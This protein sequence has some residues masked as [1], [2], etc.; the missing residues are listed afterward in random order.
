M[1]GLV[2]T[3]GD[4]TDLSMVSSLIAGYDIVVAADSGLDA[5]VR[6]G[7]SVDYV[8]GDMDSVTNRSALE[9]IPS[10]KRIVWPRDKDYTDTELAMSL[11]RDK[12][13]DQ[14]ILLGGSGGRM[15]HVYALQ[16]LFTGTNSPDMWIGT[17]S[18]VMGIGEGCLSRQV[19][20]SGLCDESPVS[21]FSASRE[22]HCISEGLVWPLDH[23]DWQHGSYSL[24]NRSKSGSCTIEAVFGRFVVIFPV[25][26][27][28]AV[29]RIIANF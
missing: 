20:I 23:V 21:V 22:G 2:F 13:V 6:L 5:A 1:K 8:V 15:D 9:R 16:S 4:M 24:S 11:M 28:I 18:I 12:G 27:K 10:S 19:I 14:I 29:Q 17:D 25:S 7:F 3:G 26:D